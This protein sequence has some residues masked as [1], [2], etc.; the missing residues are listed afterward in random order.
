M[1]K[2]TS[3][4]VTLFAFAGMAHAGETDNSMFQCMAKDTLEVDSSCVQQRIDTNVEYQNS[5]KQ[6]FNQSVNASGNVMA[7]MRFYPERHLIEV[8]AHKDALEKAAL[9]ARR[10]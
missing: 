3:L 1:R 4:I 7:T 9:L 6:F 8:V 5:Q 10:Q 2:V